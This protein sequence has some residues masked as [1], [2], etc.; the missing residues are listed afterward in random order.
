MAGGIK[1]LWAVL[2]V[3]ELHEEWGKVSAED[4]FKRIEGALEC[5]FAAARE[6]L[7]ALLYFSFR[8]SQFDSWRRKD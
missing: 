6:V 3:W 4:L 2:V 8:R 7:P 5:T 1:A